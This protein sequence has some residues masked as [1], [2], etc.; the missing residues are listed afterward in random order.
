MKKLIYILLSL[1]PFFAFSQEAAVV[2]DYFAYWHLD[3]VD[4]VDR[5]LNNPTHYCLSETIN[6]DTVFK[7]KDLKTIMIILGGQESL[8]HFSVSDLQQKIEE[9]IQRALAIKCKVILGVIDLEVCGY[10]EDE[11]YVY[12]YNKMFLDLLNYP[13]FTFHFMSIDQYYH[14]EEVDQ[15]RIL[16]NMKEAVLCAKNHK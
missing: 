13:I 15:K 9:I 5:M 3:D 7:Q 11:Y 6:I 14:S 4:A 2:G 12:S 8:H 1:L 10:C 16:K